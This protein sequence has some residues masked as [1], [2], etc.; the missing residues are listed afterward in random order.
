[1]EFVC[2]NPSCKGNRLEEVMTGVIVCSSIASIDEDGEVVYGEQINE[3]GEIF[4]YQCEECGTRLL[5][6]DGSNVTTPEELKEFL[7]D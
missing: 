1:M 7:E 6:A 2:A 5:N 4:C 3:D